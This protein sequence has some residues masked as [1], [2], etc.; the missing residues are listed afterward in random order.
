MPSFVVE[1]DSNYGP[2]RRLFTL[3]ADRALRAQMIQVLEELRLAD[4]ILAGSPGDEM[5]VYWNAKELDL[6]QSFDTQGVTVDRP[7]VLRMRPRVVIETAKPKKPLIKWRSILLPPIEGAIGALIAWF[8]GITQTDVL[9]PLTTANQVDVVMAAILTGAIALALVIGILARRDAPL[10]QSLPSVLIA[11]L[12]GL[13]IVVGI[14]LAQQ[15]PTVGGF[16]LGR[17]VAWALALALLSLIVAFPQRSLPSTRWQS[18]LGF[19]ALSGAA[20]A[21]VLT[22]PGPSLMLQAL[23]FIIGGLGVGFAAL[24]YPA[25]QAS[26]VKVAGK[27]V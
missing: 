23:A 9:R 5:A 13:T 22:L 3:D 14:F 21:I 2:E 4:R 24:G 26:G 17:V 19:G 18:A 11:P 8:I 12:A 10:G 20:A 6:S 7:L 25:W 27:A 16:L 1:F 15:S